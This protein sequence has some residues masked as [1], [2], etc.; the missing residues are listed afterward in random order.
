[1]QAKI[2]AGARAWSPDGAR[3]W[4][5]VPHSILDVEVTITG[6]LGDKYVV[7]SPRWSNG[8]P[9]S[10]L[11]E[12]ADVIPDENPPDNGGGDTNPPEPETPPVEYITIATFY[13]DGSPP[14]TEVYVPLV[15]GE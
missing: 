8:K 4:G 15:S 2:K 10:V 14:V 7:D 12:W 9:W 13:T 1:M 5:T 3:D 6:D 11:K